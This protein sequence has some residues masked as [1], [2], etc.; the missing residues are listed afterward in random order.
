MQ[1]KVFK[2]LAVLG[3]IILIWVSVFLIFGEDKNPQ[4]AAKIEFWNVFDKTEAMEPLLREF[5]TKT[6]IRVNYRS[7]TDLSEYRDTLLL[8]LAAGQG[9]DVLAVHANWLP[10]Y[11]NLLRPLPKE[12]GYPVENV[13]RDFV[14]AVADAVIFEEEIPKSDA[15]KGRVAETQI[16]GLPMYLDTLAIYFNKTYFRNILSKPYPAP[17]LT[18]AGVREDVISLTTRDTEDPEGFKLTGIA[19]GRANNITRGVDLFYALY[20]QFGGEDLTTAS[21]EIARNNSGQSY[22]PLAAALDFITSFSRNTR[23]KEYAWNS[24][25]SANSPEKEIA[26]FARGKVAMIAGY[27]YYLELIKSA[28][29]Q[30]GSIDISEVEIAPFPQILDPQAGNPKTALA[31]FFTLAVAKSSEKPFES[32]QLILD[33]TSRDSQRTYFEATNKPTS[34]RDLISEQKEN[35]LFGVFAEQAVYAD[36]LQVVND[37]LF[38]EAVASVLDRVSDGEI[39]VEEGVQELEATFA[40]AV[41]KN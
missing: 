23:N 8:E 11:K 20:Q 36:S 2:I 1:S 39:S 16:F 15:K 18:W 27:S 22:K 41:K 17:E 32:W 14:D 28:I 21:K 38:A 26:A 30:Q 4:P 24:K 3:G 31:D 7:F 35:S 40:S 37:E 29:E 19:L 33:L 25:I 12:M 10:K 6:G 34:R 5:T 13:A 9:P